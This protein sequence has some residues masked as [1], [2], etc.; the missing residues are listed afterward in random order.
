MSRVPPKS[1]NGCR[2]FN[3]PAE[4][5]SGECRSHPPLAPTVW[6]TVAS[7]DWCGEFSAII[8]PLSDQTPSLLTPYT[9]AITL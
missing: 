1:C 8:L 5:G 9:P 7:T 2:H 4:T 6:P 3:D